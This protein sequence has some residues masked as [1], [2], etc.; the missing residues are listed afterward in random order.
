M[1]RSTFSRR[2]QLAAL[3]ATVAALAACGGGDGGETAAPPTS[4]TPTPAPTPTPSPTPAPPATPTITLDL[5]AQVTVLEGETPLLTVQ[6]SSGDGSA[7]NYQWARDG[8]AYGAA[9][10]D[11]TLTLPEHPFSASYAPEAWSVAVSNAAGSVQSATAQV[12]RVNRSWQ[13]RGVAH[14]EQDYANWGEA[15]DIATLVDATDRV[16]VA[17][18]HSRYQPSFVTSVTFKGHARRGDADPWD[19]AQSIPT[20]ANG[21]PSRLQLATSWTG[22]LFAAWQEVVTVAGVERQ[23]VRAAVYRP[24]ADASQPGTWSPVGTASGEGADASDPQLLTLGGDVYGIAWLERSAAGQPR[25]ALMRRYEVPAAGEDAASGWS[26]AAPMENIAADIS[27]LALVGVGGAQNLAMFFVEHPNATL[28]AWQYSFGGMGNWSAPAA[29]AVDYR[30]DRI[31]AAAPVNG[32]TVL[33]TADGNGRLFTRRVDFT[34]NA[35]A[36]STWSYRANAYGSAPAM[37]VDAAGNIDIFGVS[38]NTTGGN[39]S[40][41]AHWRFTPAG[42]WGAANILKSSATNFAL[43]QGLRAPAVGRDGSIGNL[44]LAWQEADAGTPQRVRAMRFS[45][46]DDAW[47]EPVDIDAPG[48]GGTR[49]DGLKMAVGQDGRA[50]AVWVQDDS[51]GGSQR[52]RAARLR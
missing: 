3:S 52:L 46:Q 39:T 21:N 19:Y 36:D 8:S 9:G 17:S 47:T 34:Q 1:T 2:L 16:H 4:G 27:R 13:D 26:P 10:S 33:G 40:V 45:R 5:P 38:V 44:V 50:T 22:S 6:A 15:G 25:S 12:L 14:P 11:A 51:V 31:H 24:N 37:L 7:L 48:A 28:S 23:I 49:Q 35:F 42:G 32:I 41:L 29:L 30:F 20:L 43:E 18:I